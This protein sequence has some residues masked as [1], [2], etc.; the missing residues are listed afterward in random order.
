MKKKFE[1]KEFFKI[2]IGKKSI[3]V[4]SVILF[5]MI[6]RMDPVS[7]VSNKVSPLIVLGVY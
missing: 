5:V 6:V 3:V 2:P 7:G 1:E 4:T